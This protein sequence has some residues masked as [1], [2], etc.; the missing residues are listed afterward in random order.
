[1][2]LIS[3]TMYRFV[4]GRVSEEWEL[5]DKLGLYQQLGVSPPPLDHW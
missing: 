4:E 3:M 1:M 5:F 2:R